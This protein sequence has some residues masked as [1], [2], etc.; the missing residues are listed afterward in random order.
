MPLDNSNSHNPLPVLPQTTSPPPTQPITDQP[1]PA[2]PAQTPT[3]PQQP[4]NPNVL[5]P[6][7]TKKLF[8]A[9]F[10]ILFFL[11]LITA[12]TAIALAYN[13]YPL[14]KPPK[15]IASA[16]DN[17]ITISPL[18]KPSRIVMDSV[19]AKSSS[20]KNANQKTEI[21][22][23]TTSPDSPI[24][25]FK[26]AISGPIDF[27]NN[28]RNTAEADISMEV[29]F[30]GASFNGTA[31]VKTIENTI[32][33]KISEFPFSS[34]Y[35]QLV[36][37]KNKWFYWQIPK[38]Y[39]TKDAKKTYYEKTGQIFSNFL[40]KSRAWTKTSIDTSGDYLLDVTPPKNE[41]DKLVFDIIKIYATQNT[42]EEKILQS[43][44]E[45]NVAKNTEK[46]ANLK[47]TATAAKDNFYLKRANVSFDLTPENLTLPI[48]GQESLMPA[49][50]ATYNFK[51]S[52]ELSNYNKQIVIVP[53]ENAED[54]QSVV[55]SMTKNPYNSLTL[56]KDDSPDAQ[57][58]N[59]IGSL[60]TALQAYAATNQESYPANLDALVETNNLKAL[61]I[62]PVQTGLTSYPYLKDPANCDGT[63]KGRCTEVALYTPLTQPKTP[64]NV[65]CFQSITYQAQE[66]PKAQCVAKKAAAQQ[67][68]NG[69]TIEELLS[70]KS[71][72]LGVKTG[73]DLEL[74]KLFANFIK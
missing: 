43:V 30:E 56:K 45:E 52:T 25:S 29:K 63:E 28:A 46:L 5:Y 65:W 37:Y 14:V 18:P 61:P 33:F 35:G 74:L 48:T 62:P 41:L 47:I 67:T 31:S 64:G 1:E 50:K 39:I 53:P 12:S 24:T 11:T 72:V 9:A 6:R 55:D 66:L 27:E 16:I 60:A 71:P 23:S 69:L 44:Q 7:S 40:E 59:D 54:F 42:Q 19:I 20:L 26:L 4:P 73:W 51:I 21:S 17:L 38:Q 2:T 34:L 68:G 57:V 15:L 49:A 3:P 36:P 70:P 8:F 58:K 32:Y 10:I 22:L 13:N